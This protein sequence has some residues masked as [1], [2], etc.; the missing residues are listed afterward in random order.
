MLR[1]NIRAIYEDLSTPIT[2]EECVK[3][4]LNESVKSCNKEIAYIYRM[5]L[6]KDELKVLRKL[7]GG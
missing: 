5:L 1:D 4:R 2:F 7:N 6:D 3:V